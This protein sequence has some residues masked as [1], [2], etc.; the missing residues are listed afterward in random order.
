ME[1]EKNLRQDVHPYSLD[2]YEVRTMDG[3]DE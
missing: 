1:E 3:D 2:S